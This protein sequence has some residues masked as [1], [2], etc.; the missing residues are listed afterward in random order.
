MHTGQELEV[1]QVQKGRLS[2]DSGAPQVGSA[3]SN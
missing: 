2:C 3:R 1:H